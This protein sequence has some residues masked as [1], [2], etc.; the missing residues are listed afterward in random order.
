MNLTKTKLLVN[1][2]FAFDLFN[3]GIKLRGRCINK[4]QD[5]VCGLWPEKTGVQG[6]DIDMTF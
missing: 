5:S 2:S 6:L 1:T 4:R 3:E